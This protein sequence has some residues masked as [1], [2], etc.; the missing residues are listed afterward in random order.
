MFKELN[1]CW[2]PSASWLASWQWPGW[3]DPQ[4]A[5]LTKCWNVL[6]TY[7]INKQVFPFDF[8]LFQMWKIKLMLEKTMPWSVGWCSSAS[9]Q[10]PGSLSHVHVGFLHPMLVH[11]S[12][13]MCMH[14]KTGGC[15]RVFNLPNIFNI[16][17]SLFIC[18]PP[19]FGSSECVILNSFLFHIQRFCFPFS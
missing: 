1:T 19:I 15:Q 13:N 17:W 10:C 9:C 6:P 12:C 11:S 4:T 16:M 14:W 2:V 5:S 7:I 18:A 3:I 8:T